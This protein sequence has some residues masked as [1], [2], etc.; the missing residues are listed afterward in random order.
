[1]D[2]TRADDIPQVFDEVNALLTAPHSENKVKKTFFQMLHNKA[3][4]PYGF[5]RRVLYE[6]LGNN[7]S[8]LDGAFRCSPC[9]TTSTFS[10]YFSEI[11]LLI[12]I[13]EAERIQ[14]YKQKVF[15]KALHQPQGHLLQ[16]GRVQL[17]PQVSRRTGAPRQINMTASRGI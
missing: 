12:N 14:K 10:S 15:K 16:R 6:L 5:S 11:I 4:G 13:N 3:L 7:Q 1:M 17:G 9:W 8:G 2:E